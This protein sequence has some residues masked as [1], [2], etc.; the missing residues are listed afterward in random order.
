MSHRILLLLAL[1]LSPVTGRGPLYAQELLPA[2]EPGPGPLF[3]PE[4][5]YVNPLHF[6]LQAFGA[7]AL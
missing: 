3:N 5:Y 7:S 4:D 6:A 2:D 1:M